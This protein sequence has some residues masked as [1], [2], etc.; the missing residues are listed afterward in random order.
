M[1]IFSRSTSYADFVF[2][3][4]NDFAD[5]ALNEIRDT[6]PSFLP[7]VSGSDLLWERIVELDSKPDVGISFNRSCRI[8]RAKDGFLAFNLAREEDW[9][10]L[11]A[12]LEMESSCQSWGELELSV[13]R[14][15]SRPLLERARLMGL[16]VSIPGDDEVLE[17]WLDELFTSD[18]GFSA[19]GDLKILDFS[20][21]WAGPL[22]SHLLL[23]LGC[24]VLKIESKDRRDFSGDATPRLFSLLN[25]DK[26][27]L[28]VDFQ[29]QSELDALQQMM[30][31]ADVVIEG[32][33][34]RAFKSLGID[35]SSIKSL[36]TES[37]YQRQLW[38]S[39]TA[40]GRFDRAADWVGF[41]D[42]VAACAGLL[43]R[44]S[45]TDCHFVGDAIADPLAGLLSAR[46]ITRCFSQN[47]RGLLDFSLFRAARVALGAVER[48]DG[49]SFAPIKK[50]RSR[51]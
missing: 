14:K 31:E 46:T 15:A 35:R 2:R 27:L 7:S 38:V 47:L 29:D 17:I 11:P 3:N 40:Y 42:D 21:L 8:I 51:C 36:Q 9:S 19:Y 1:S 18:V 30:C 4:I 12:L 34:P 32:S 25:K 22:C 24:N 20:S 48:P 10:L 33:R 6:S 5:H 45:S 39:L 41:G 23:N 26:E 44:S 37:Q 50:V 43:D 16:P 28:V 49:T 13:K